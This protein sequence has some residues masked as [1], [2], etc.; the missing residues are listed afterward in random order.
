MLARLIVVSGPDLGQAFPVAEGQTLVVGRGDTAQVRLSDPCV[1]RTH[2]RLEA[3]QGR[4]R[5]AR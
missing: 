3:A 2:C 4:V 1:S 5:R